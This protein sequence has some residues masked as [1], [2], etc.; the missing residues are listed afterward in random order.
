MRNKKLFKI[1]PSGLNAFLLFGSTQF[2][3]FKLQEVEIELIFFF[4]IEK[5]Y[6]FDLKLWHLRI[7]RE[8][9][10]VGQTEGKKV[11]LSGMK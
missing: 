1:V 9:F 3:N 2:F 6:H 4:K 10:R 7:E 5:T 11:R 8:R